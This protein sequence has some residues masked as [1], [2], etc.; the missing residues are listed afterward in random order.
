MVKEYCW[1]YWACSALSSIYNLWNV[2]SNVILRS[3]M[4]ITNKYTTFLCAR[5][6]LGR[7]LPY[8][9]DIYT[10]VPLKPSI[11]Q[12]FWYIHDFFH[13]LI[14]L[15]CANLFAYPNCGLKIAC[16]AW[17]MNLLTKWCTIYVWWRWC[18]IVRSMATVKKL[19]FVL[20]QFFNMIVE[21]IIEE[22]YKI[23]K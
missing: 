17:F 23:P 14:V 5:I 13:H 2:R 3:V 9:V 8:N 6:T 7:C 22:K 1:S 20:R 21:D 10:Y 16:D 19:F 4:W 15:L 11:I 12:V 18:G